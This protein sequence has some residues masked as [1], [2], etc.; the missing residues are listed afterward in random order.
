MNTH[1][2]IDIPDLQGLVV[3]GYNQHVAARYLMLKVGDPAG[4]RAWLG[5]IVDTVTPGRPR[6]GETAV[7]VALTWPGL[8]KIG[9]SPLSPNTNFAP[10]FISGMVQGHR[11]RILGDFDESDPGNWAWGGPANPVDIVLMLFALDWPQLDGLTADHTARLAAHGLTVVQRLETSN[12]HGFEPFGFRDGISQ[13]VIEGL[14]SRQGTAA[15]TVKAGEFIL[16]YANEYGQYTDRPMLPASDDPRGLLPRSSDGMAD[17]GRNGTYLVFRTLRQDVEGF[18]RFLTQASSGPDG[19]C[20][21]KVRDHLAARMVGRWPGGAP[22]AQSPRHDDPALADFNDFAYHAKDR[23][24]LR[25]PIGAHIRR[26]NP[27]DSLDPDPGSGE[28]IAIGK[29]HRLLRRG[30]EYGPP[31]KPDEP[32]QASD[33]PAERGIQFLCFNANI[34]RQFEFI[35][36][37]WINN[38]KFDGLYDDADPLVGAR[39]LLDAAGTAAA[40]QDMPDGSTFTIQARPVRQRVCNLPR[41]VSVRGG[42]YFFMPGIRALRYLAGGSRASLQ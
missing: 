6:P 41:F 23:F 42:A 2:Q 8:S 10:E 16:G 35:Q 11:S 15:N 14:S 36:F 9:L 19:S 29:R 3:R 13:P 21:P 38:P 30:R 18:H 1:E 24:G 33:P 12:L 40:A 28:S 25:C 27:R 17:L 39:G 4:A 22:L 20:D 32:Q 26:S 34:A 37:T 5:S 31:F 7:N